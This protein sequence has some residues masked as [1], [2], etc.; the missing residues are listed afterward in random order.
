MTEDHADHTADMTGTDI[1]S[2]KMFVLV[3]II[4][5]SETLWSSIP[6]LVELPQAVTG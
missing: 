6:L 2:Y 5:L 3:L 4:H 1:E